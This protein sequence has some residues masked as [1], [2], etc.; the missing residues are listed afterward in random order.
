MPH[1]EAGEAALGAQVVAVLG[2]VR[3]GSGPEKCG[4]V[5]DGFCICIRRL[6]GEMP[7]EAAIERSLERLVAGICSA[8]DE[9]D[10]GKGGE[11]AARGEVAGSG[12]WL[13][14]VARADQ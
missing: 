14:Q 10:A 2:E 4:H 7:G 12:Q 9:E 13:I 6:Q 1:I 3:V 11:W 5:V 8:F